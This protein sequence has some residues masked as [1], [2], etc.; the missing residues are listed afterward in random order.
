M[1]IKPRFIDPIYIERCRIPDDDAA[2]I[3]NILEEAAAKYLDN[4][5]AR[6]QTY[7]K[8]YDLKQVCT[9]GQLIFPQPDTRI[10]RYGYDEFQEATVQITLKPILSFRHAHKPSQVFGKDLRTRLAEAIQAKLD[11]HGLDHYTAR[12]GD[13]S[14]IDVTPAKLDKAYALEFLVDRLNLQGFTRHGRKLGSNTIYF[15]DEVIVGGGND[16]PVTRIP[17]LLVFAVNA[18]KDFVPFLSQDFV[19]SAI[20]EGLFATAEVLAHFNRCARTLLSNFDHPKKG[21]GHSSAK[22]ALEALKEKIFVTRIKDKISELR[23][24]D[25][26]DVEDWQVL[27]AFVTIMRRNDPAARRWLSILVNELDEIMTQLTTSKVS[28]QPALGTSHPDG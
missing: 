23:H 28:V 11:D 3:L 4:L 7:E 15:G 10:V 1:A 14:S 5:R 25:Y 6:R 12:P 24:A 21:L 20:L 22:T 13:R 9:D 16:Y 17:G 26:L 18:D 2:K 19:P 27:H 8:S